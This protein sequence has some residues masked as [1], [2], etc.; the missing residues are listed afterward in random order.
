MILA[1]EVG[2]ID[3][4][5]WAV[6]DKR[7]DLL[8]INPSGD[9]ALRAT[10]ARLASGTE[11]ALEIQIAP[12]LQTSGLNRSKMLKIY[13][14]AIETARDNDMMIVL[15]SGARTPIELRSPVAM[16]HIGILLGLERSYAEKATDEFPSTI[17][18][19]NLKKLDPDYVTAGVELIKES[20]RG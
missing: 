2:P 13:R 5:N 19:R 7:I 20:K 10:T 9:H 18:L 3:R 14:E 12:L 8:T 6:E 4:I 16:T 15:T 11:V 17:V 1:L